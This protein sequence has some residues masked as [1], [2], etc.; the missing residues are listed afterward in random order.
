MDL[1]DVGREVVEWILLAQ[2]SDRGGGAFAIT[3]MNP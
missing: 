1:R 2:D 3:V